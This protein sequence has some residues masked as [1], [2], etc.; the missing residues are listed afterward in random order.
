[1]SQQMHSEQINRDGPASYSAGYEE[2]PHPSTY[3]IGT[4]G[5]KLPGHTTGTAPTAGQR[6]A[7]AIISILVLT[8][9]SFV[10]IGLSF[11]T[12]QNGN[13]AVPVLSMFLIVLALLFTAII[14]INAL[15]NRRH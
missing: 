14:V 9:M 4:F 7:L 15:F 2:A 11:L 5:Q 1:M 13:E 10:G 8:F 6:L 3:S 12:S